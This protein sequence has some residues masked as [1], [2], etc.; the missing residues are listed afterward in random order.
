MEG[1]SGAA[2]VP[3]CCYLCQPWPAIAQKEALRK[4]T[5]TT[6]LD[7]P[8][9]LLLGPRH[10][11]HGCCQSTELAPYPT[12]DYV[13]LFSPRWWLLVGVKGF[14]PHWVGV[15]LQNTW[16]EEVTTSRVSLSRVLWT[17]ESQIVIR[18]ACTRN[19]FQTHTAVL[20]WV[21]TEHSAWAFSLGHWL[22]DK[23]TPSWL[24]EPFNGCRFNMESLAF[25]KI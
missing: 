14:F 9:Y 15:S 11:A 1:L 5:R 13:C 10:N 20:F 18:S 4:L 2:Y 25:H 22:T 16:E 3:Y 21:K 24:C 19:Q 6:G 8:L 7:E 12:P 17:Q 23:E